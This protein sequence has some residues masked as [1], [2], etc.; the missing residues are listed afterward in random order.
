[1]Q[2]RTRSWWLG[3]LSLPST[4]MMS[5]LLLLSLKY[6]TQDSI[7]YGWWGR[8]LQRRWGLNN[9]QNDGPWEVGPRWVVGRSCD[10][11]SLSRAW[12]DPSDSVAMRILSLDRHSISTN[13]QFKFSVFD[14]N[15]QWLIS[16]FFN[17]TWKTNGGCMTHF[18]YG[19]I[20]SGKMVG[21]PSD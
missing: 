1:M 17:I 2:N 5:L 8:T 13:D 4:K 16:P 12:L 6:L 11:G 10:H 15:C 9:L 19:V 20:S 7:R 18:S 3:S 21:T 14:N